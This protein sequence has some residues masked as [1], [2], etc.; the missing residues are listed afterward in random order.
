[1]LV[2][3]P[4]FTPG[5]PIPLDK[6]GLGDLGSGDLAVVRK[7]RGRA[8]L[9]RALGPADRIENVL[10]GL[11]EHE[12][13][14]HEF[15][16]FDLPEPSLEGRVDLRELLTFTIDPETAKD[17]DDAISTRRE[18]DGI[19]VWVHIADVSWFV[20]AGSPLD[21]GAAERALSVY[22]PGLRRADASARARG[23]RLL[24]PTERRPPLRHRRDPLR[25]LAAGRRADLLPLGDPLER[26]ADVRAGRVDHRRSRACGGRRH[27]GAQARRDDRARAP[28]PPVRARRA[29]H[30]RRGDRVRVRRGGRSGEGVARVGAARARA[31]R[32]ADDPRERG[33]RRAA[34]RPAARGALPRARAAGATVGHTTAREADVGRGADSCRRP[35]RTT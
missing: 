29:A 25:R 11:L 22:V 26:A 4:V 32:G 19:R 33:R 15:E 34:G 24:A 17:F 30:R 6:H 9:E 18:G 20:P 31:D 35:T 3:E 21:R 2:G 8:R 13:L 14:R 10:E 28:A 27:R 5:V 16:P 1:M 7:Q 12:G 23:R